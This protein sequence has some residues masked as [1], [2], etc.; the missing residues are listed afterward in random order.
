MLII[1][2]V[3]FPFIEICNGFPVILYAPDS[4][5][6]DSYN[7]YLELLLRNDSDLFI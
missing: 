6:I 4:L 7:D 1:D 2:D 5:P 3:I